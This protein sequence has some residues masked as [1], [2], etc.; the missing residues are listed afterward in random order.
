M[1]A[2]CISF[3]FMCIYVC[4][5]AILF[6]FGTDSQGLFFGS[7]GEG[8]SEVLRGELPDDFFLGE[9]LGGVPGDR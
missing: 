9:I 5:I 8:G 4:L 3:L 2:T 6:F 7:A 1:T